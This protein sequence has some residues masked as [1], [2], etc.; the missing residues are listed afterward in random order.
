MLEQP[1]T[2][3]ISFSKPGFTLDLPAE[4]LERLY[5][6]IERLLGAIEKLHRIDVTDIEPDFL[7]P[8]EEQ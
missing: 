1:E 2:G 8:C 7:A 4:S 5:P 6:Q 3:N